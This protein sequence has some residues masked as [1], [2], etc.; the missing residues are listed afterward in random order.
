MDIFAAL[1]TGAT[2][3]PFDLR[4]SGVQALLQWLSE[5][6]ITVLHTVATVFRQLGRY[7]KPGDK[8]PDLRVID[9]GGES[10]PADIMKTFRSPAIPADCI[11][12]NGLGT[13]ELN[14]ACQFFARKQTNIDGTVVPVGRAVRDTLVML[15]D[16]DSW[17]RSG[18]DVGEIA[19]QSR[20]LAAGY[21]DDPEVERAAFLDAGAGERIYRTGDLGRF[22]EDGSLELVGRKVFRAS[23][24]GNI[25][26]TMEVEIALRALD[27]IDD[28][29]VVTCPS[30][31]TEQELVAF[32]VGRIPSDSRLE[33]TRI[34]RSL[35]QV[36]P[37]YAIPSRLTWID[38]LPLTDTGKVDRRA[39]TRDAGGSPL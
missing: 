6:R 26:D 4:R 39:L 8:F 20:Y 29:V 21:W 10:V 33:V 11:L 1:L 28:A 23:V 36:L 14:V 7:L 25:V 16:P 19:F 3:I 9:F 38:E 34:R 31:S 2:L 12:V 17:A 30:R 37:H 5:E 13:T 27:G 24:N 32:L 22:R 18:D 15:L 35:T